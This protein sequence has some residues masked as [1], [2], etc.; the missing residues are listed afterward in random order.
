MVA[1]AELWLQF[2]E[3]NTHHLNSIVFYHLP[4]LTFFEAFKSRSG[5]RRFMFEEIWS[6]VEGCEETII[7]A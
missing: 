3:I 1:N 7:S 4:I 6:T 5:K 2:S